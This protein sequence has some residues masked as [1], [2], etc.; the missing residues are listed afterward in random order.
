MHHLKVCAGGWP[1]RLLCVMCNQESTLEAG[2][3]WRTVLGMTAVTVCDRA[4]SIFLFC[5]ACNQD[6]TLEAGPRV[7]A[8]V[9]AY[10]D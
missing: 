5:A 10:E 9:V 6:F 8:I 3:A 2:L 4:A 1:S 7:Q